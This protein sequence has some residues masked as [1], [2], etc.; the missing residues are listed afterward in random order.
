MK[1]NKVRL[2]SLFIKEDLINNV[3]LFTGIILFWLSVFSV[4]QKK[5]TL[6]FVFTLSYIVLMIFLRYS[7]LNRN[8]QTVL[9]FLGFYLLITVNLL[10]QE[11]ATYFLVMLQIVGVF[12]FLNIQRI[13]I[14]I[15]ILFLVLIFDFFF[16]K[17]R[18]DL[19]FVGNFAIVYLLSIY[20]AFTYRDSVLKMLSKIEELSITDGL[21]GLLNQ[22]GFLKKLEEEYYR[23][24]RYNKSFSLLMLDSD[25]LKR[26]NDVFGHRYGNM[27]IK[28]IAEVIKDNCRRTDFAGRYGGDE[29][30]LCLVETELKSAKEF[31]ERL[32]KAIEIKSLFTDKG[33]DFKVT[34][35]IG[36]ASFPEC[37][38][39]LYDIIE[40]ADRALY[41]AKSEGKNRVRC[42]VKN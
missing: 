18:G 5:S 34:I 42:A 8:V 3:C 31:A 37:G 28:L 10:F 29:Y 23:S 15:S 11:S 7:R 1:D 4:E 20:I 2:P 9:H 6:F 12:L 32:R 24:V 14:T 38:E 39:N 27:V 40:N 16:F 33:K 36:I 41:M 26:I 13:C 17:S 35:S 22:K 21:T 25:D 30:M 19:I